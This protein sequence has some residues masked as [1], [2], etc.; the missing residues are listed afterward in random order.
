MET[1]RGIITLTKQPPKVVNAAAPEGDGAPDVTAFSS[2]PRSRPAAGAALPTA[3][4]PSAEPT[5]AMVA[6]GVEVL[7][8]S[9]AVEGQLSS[10]ELLVAEI[11]QAMARAAH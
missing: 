2:R 3:F 6:A 9:G 7:W 10:D 1:P 11:F 8:Q 5:D 4:D